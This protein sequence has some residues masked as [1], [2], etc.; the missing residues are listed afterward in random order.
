MHRTWQVK[1]EDEHKTLNAIIS[2]VKY[3]IS[4]EEILQF[5]SPRSTPILLSRLAIN[6]QMCFISE[7]SALYPHAASPSSL[8][9]LASSFIHTSEDSITNDSVLSLFHRSVLSDSSVIPWTL[10]QQAALSM[11]FS[12]QEHWSGLPSPSPRDLPDTG[13]VPGS[14][15]HFL[16]FRLFCTRS[17]IFFRAASPAGFL[18]AVYKLTATDI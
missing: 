1:S 9:N 11:G 15:A 3:N 10:G 17:L 16:Y 5:M 14:P 2:P 13:I 7:L 4:H 12:R 18:W 6:I 8:E